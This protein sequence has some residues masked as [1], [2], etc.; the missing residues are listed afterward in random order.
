MNWTFT[1]D[2]SGLIHSQTHM[3]EIG[4]VLDDEY[5]E[6]FETQPFVNDRIE[7]LSMVMAQG[8]ANFPSLRRRRMRSVI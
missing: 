5:V 8:A 4:Y 2:V 6:K 1:H 7:F 3:V